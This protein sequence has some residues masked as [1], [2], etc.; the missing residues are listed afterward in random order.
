M[1]AA[2]TTKFSS[3]K[4]T[5]ATIGDI[6]DLI[7]AI[8][9]GDPPTKEDWTIIL[10]LNALEGTDLDWLR[11]NLITQFTSSKTR[12]TEKEVIEAINLAG[13]DRRQTEQ[14]HAFKTQKESNP[15]QK[16][17]CSNCGNNRHVIE[18]CWAKG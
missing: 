18:C 10:M 16:M 9:E 3:S 2:I 1:R 6:R 12:P 11:K 14:V 15:K 17:K 5:N 13:Y 4:A 7:T 8:F